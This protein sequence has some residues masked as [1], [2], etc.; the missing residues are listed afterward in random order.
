MHGR[1]FAKK[2]RL[3]LILLMN[4]RKSGAS[5]HKSIMQY[6]IFFLEQKLTIVI[7]YNF[8]PQE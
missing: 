4:G 1:T 2:L 5:F 3:A 8:T 7:Y 6:K